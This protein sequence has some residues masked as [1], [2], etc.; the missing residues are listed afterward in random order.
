MSEINY[1][2]FFIMYSDDVTVD[3]DHLY[4]KRIHLVYSYYIV[5]E[6]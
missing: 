5:I 6:D 3:V 2:K 1:F 4:I